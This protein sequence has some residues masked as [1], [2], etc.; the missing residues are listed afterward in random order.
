[1]KAI[2]YRFRNSYYIEKDEIIHINNFIN[3]F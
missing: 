1:M 2:G 3:I